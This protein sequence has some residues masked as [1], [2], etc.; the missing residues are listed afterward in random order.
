MVTKNNTK[1]P[2]QNN[3]LEKAAQQIL[4]ECLGFDEGRAYYLI[5]LKRDKDL[6]KEFSYSKKYRLLKNL[7][8]SGAIGKIKQEDREFFS[9]IP[10]PPSFLHEKN[11]PQS[12]ILFLEELYLEHHRSLLQDTAFSQ[13]I[14]RDVR[15]FIL[16]LLKHIMK[17][18][19][20][21][22][23]AGITPSQLS[24]HIQDKE[25]IQKI[26]LKPSIL[27][28]RHLGIIDNS[29][30]FEFLKIRN[31]DSYDY[32]GYIAGK[33]NQKDSKASNSYMDGIKA[34]FA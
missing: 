34:E 2:N 28:K 9:Y 12:I 31:K 22:L 18:N 23:G 6:E 25:K 32:I 24:T 10:L 8:D 21:I 17:E 19:A 14:L 7:F 13:I 15:G 30:G 5:L 11:H 29:L 4:G 16:F 3:L 20:S 33:I 26:T 27:K 1:N